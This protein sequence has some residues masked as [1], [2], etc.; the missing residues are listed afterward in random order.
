MK[1]RSQNVYVTEISTFSCCSNL[2]LTANLSMPDMQ[3]KLEDSLEADEE[4][5]VRWSTK[6]NVWGL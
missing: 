6:H 4:G 3:R 5:E 1:S 2:K